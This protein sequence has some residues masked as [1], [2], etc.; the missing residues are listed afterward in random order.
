MN[1]DTPS[2]RISR[3]SAG[4]HSLVKLV[5]AGLILVMINFVAFKHYVHKDLST[6]QFY[7]LSAKTNEVLA[8]LDSPVTIYTFLNDRLPD[9]SK[10]ISNLIKEYQHLGGK[11]VIVDKIDPSFDPAHALDLQKKLHF[12]G[13]DNMV[14][15]QYKDRSP[16]FVK[17]E[18]FFDINPMSGQV[19]AFKGE[20]QLT[21]ALLG[22]VEGTASKVYFTEGHGERSIR[23]ANPT[24]TGFGMVADML[25][26]DNIEATTLN[27]SSKGEVPADAEAVIIAGPSIMFSTFEAEALDKYLAN[28]GK[29]LILLDPYVVSGLDSMLKKYGIKFEDDVVLCRI[30]DTTGGQTTMPLAL[31]YQGGFSAQPITTK[32]AQNGFQLLVRNARSIT[33]PPAEQSQAQSKTQFLLQTDENSWGWF[34]KNGGA[35]DTSKVVFN[36]ITDLQGPLTIGAQYDGGTTTDPATKATKFATRVVAVGAARFLENANQDAVGSNFFT[37]SVDWLVKKNAVLDISPKIPQ[38][39]SLTLNPISLRTLMWCALFFI[40]GAALAMGIFTW[41]SR[42]K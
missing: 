12:T 6:S 24:S 20:Q 5:L 22:L 17:Q 39:Y 13:N 21:G 2:A 15:L 8:K 16:R 14:I 36:K 4:R 31:I 27:L 41:F 38:Q 33:L 37:N 3:R 26:N 42:R 34:S 1:T 7:T 11:N 18:E 19:G 29:L 23:D 25:K 28:N 32:F 30:M 35:A 10:Q 40:P 9:Q